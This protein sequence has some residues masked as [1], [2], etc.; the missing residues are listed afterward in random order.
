MHRLPLPNARDQ[1]EPPRARF[2]VRNVTAASCRPR[3][4]WTPGRYPSRPV[5]ELRCPRPEIEPPTLGAARIQARVGERPRPPRCRRSHAFRSIAE[6]CLA[7]RLRKRRAEDVLRDL[8]P[9]LLLQEAAQ[10]LGA[11][12]LRD[13]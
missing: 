1:T 2:P 7:F 12:D 11:L 6:N 13:P 4:S 3:P 5:S 8:G 10:Q 9:D